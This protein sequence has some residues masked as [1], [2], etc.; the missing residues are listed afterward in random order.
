MKAGKLSMLSCFTRYHNL[1]PAVVAILFSCAP[2]AWSDVDVLIGYYNINAK[3]NT[4]GCPESSPDLYNPYVCPTSL[5]PGPV[6]IEGLTAG[7]YRIEITGIGTK[8]QSAFL[9]WLGDA[10]GM[11]FWMDGP[12]FSTITATEFLHPGG[13]I[14]MYWHDWYAADNDPDYST[15]IALFQ[16]KATPK[17]KNGCMNNGW[18]AFGFKNQGHCIRFCDTGKW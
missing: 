2:P 17:S 12:L 16:I 18:K 6:V 14:A 13:N 15:D 1:L 3:F 11:S 5:P 7:K 4:A 10:T 8:G 9:V